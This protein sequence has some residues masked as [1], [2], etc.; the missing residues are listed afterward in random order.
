[1]RYAL[2]VAD[3][4][5]YNPQ[6]IVRSAEPLLSPSWSPDGSKLA[7]VSFERGNSAIYIQNIGTGARAGHQ[8]PRHQQRPGV[9][10]G[11]PQAGPD[12]VAQATRKST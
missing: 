11:R 9:L 12:P 1:M 8:L 4:D 7:Y 10:A 3:S 2:M 5:G 6:T